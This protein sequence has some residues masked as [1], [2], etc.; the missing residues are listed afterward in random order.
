MIDPDR[1]SRSAEEDPGRRGSIST[2]ADAKSR[3][4]VQ[5]HRR[6]QARSRVLVIRHKPCLVVSRR[7]RIDPCP[8]LGNL[9]R[10]L[11]LLFFNC[12]D[13][14]IDP[15]GHEV[16]LIFLAPAIVQSRESRRGY[17]SKKNLIRRPGAAP[18]RGFRRAA[19]RGLPARVAW[20]TRASPDEM[21]S[22]DHELALVRACA[23]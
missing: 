4:R 12:S 10:K 21:P 6:D 16:E 15:C 11:L 23:A 19:H 3:A 2:G 22:P 17:R 20:R 8:D 9:L 5:T 14:V 13:P 7:R 18:V 1:T